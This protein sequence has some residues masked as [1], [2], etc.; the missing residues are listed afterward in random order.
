MS[1]YYKTGLVCPNFETKNLPDEKKNFLW[2]TSINWKV[3]EEMKLK[4]EIDIKVL[5]I[6]DWMGKF[7]RSKKIQTIQY[8]GETYYWFCHKKIRDELPRLGMTHNNTV[9]VKI[10]PLVDE[11]LLRKHPS[12]RQL[13]KSYY[14]ITEKGLKLI[15]ASLF[16]TKDSE[17]ATA[18]SA[19]TGS[20]QN[21]TKICQDLQNTL[22]KTCQG[23]AGVLDKNMSGSLQIIEQALDI[24]LSTIIEEINTIENPSNLIK[25]SHTPS[26]KKVCEVNDKKEKNTT[27]AKIDGE[28]KE[29]QVFPE[30]KQPPATRKLVMDLAD[31]FHKRLTSKRVDTWTSNAIQKLDELGLSLE[32]ALENFEAYK[33]LRRKKESGKFIPLSVASF[34]G[35]LRKGFEED[36]SA[37]LKGLSKPKVATN[38]GKNQEA[39][40]SEACQKQFSEFHGSL[41]KKLGREQF[42]KLGFHDWAFTKSQGKK[43]RIKCPENVIEI[44]NIWW[45]SFEEYFGRHGYEF[46]LTRVPET[47]KNEGK[48]ISQ[49]KSGAYAPKSGMDCL[50][51]LENVKISTMEKQMLT[52]AF[53]WSQADFDQCVNQLGISENEKQL[54]KSKYRVR[55]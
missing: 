27:Q 28:S 19:P 18:N 30:Q 16:K 8:K 32:D 29:M 54:L 25:N 46:V 2:R 48:A 34:E 13:Q 53:T 31:Y 51:G 43:I 15:N 24:K 47:K 37:Q 33:E 6:L 40:N 50:A 20:H 38:T 7:A 1:Q 52:Q 17:Q 21:L 11:G 35:Y 26:D 3:A 10:K 49:K 9:K 44:K 12:C 23:L 14:A 45:D 55:A 5:V 36:F 39:R 41:F 4:P 42:V 22:T